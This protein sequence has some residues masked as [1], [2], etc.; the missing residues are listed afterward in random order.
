VLWIAGTRPDHLS[1]L[2]SPD[3]AT[4]KTFSKLCPFCVQPLTTWIRSRLPD[5]GS[6]TA[7]TTNFGAVPLPPAGIGGRS[8]P[9]GTPPAY[10]CFTQSPA[11][12]MSVL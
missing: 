4:S 2:R 12:R 7:Q 6:F 1:G 3:H 5:V 10:D 8:A 11:F 9:I